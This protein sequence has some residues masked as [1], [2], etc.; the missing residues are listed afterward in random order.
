MKA[1]FWGSL[2]FLL[3]F[4]A[5]DE[6]IASRVVIVIMSGSDGQAEML[7]ELNNSKPVIDRQYVSIGN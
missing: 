2:I 4:L 1:R 3:F 5:I 7:L 6:A